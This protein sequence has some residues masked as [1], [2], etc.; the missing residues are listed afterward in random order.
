LDK[1]SFISRF[2]DGVAVFAHQKISYIGY[3]IHNYPKLLFLQKTKQQSLEQENSKLKQQVE[4]YDML[5]KQQKNLNQDKDSINSLNNLSTIY[6]KFNTVISRAIID[7]NYLVNNKL[8]IDKGS[9]DGIAVGD[10]IVNQQGVIGQVFI[11]N[12]NN[13]QIMLI[14][15]PD[16]KIYVQSK[17]TNSKMLA[18]GI[19]NN[20][21]IVKYINKTTNLKI[22]DILVTTGLD[23]IYPANLAVAKISKIFYENNGFNS[24]ICQPVADYNNLQFVAV[25][26]NANK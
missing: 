25:L 7:I 24:A 17:D 9:K 10:A 20:N 23:D 15:N 26:K 11:T 12:N 1:Y 13:S 6:D 5:L 8:L 4:Q 19:G 3:Q 21:L 14:T 22:G 16:F 18:Q 2:R